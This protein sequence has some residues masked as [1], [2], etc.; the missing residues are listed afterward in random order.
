MRHLAAILVA[1]VVGFSSLMAKDEAS[2]IARLH[3]L[4]DDLINPKIA[5]YNGRLVKEMGDGMLLEFRSVVEAVRFAI[6]VQATIVSRISDAPIDDQIV[7]RMGVNLGDVVVNDEDILG[8]G[9][10]LAAR[11]ESHAEPG[12]ICISASAYDQ[13]AGKIDAT[14]EPLGPVE[15]KNIAN[16]VEVFSVKIDEK[17]HSLVTPVVAAID[18]ATAY[19]S[20]SGL[21]VTAAVALALVVGGLFWWQPWI[22]KVEPA[23]LTAMT[24]DLPDKPSIV[25]LPFENFSG[26]SEQDYFAN[27]MTDDL[28]TGLSHLPELFVISRNT[29]FTYKDQPVTIRDVAEE[30]GVQYVMEGSV[31]RVGN[32]VRINVQLIDALSGYHVWAEK[33]D[34]QM[35]DVFAIQDEVVG[36]IVGAMATNIL[37]DHA[38]M[39]QTESTLAYDLLLQGRE[40][41]HAN[42][43]EDYLVA[44]DLFNQALD[45]DKDFN[46]AHAALAASYWEI[47]DNSWADRAGLTT[48]QAADRAREHLALAHREP[49]S[50]ARRVSARIALWSGNHDEALS[51]IARAIEIDP[52]DADSFNV[53][54]YIQVRAGLPEEAEQSARTAMRLN[55]HYTDFYLR[56]LSRALFHQG[57]YEEA[58]QVIERAIKT[59]PEYEYNYP[60]LASIYGQLGEEEK[61]AQAV[62]KYHELRGNSEGGNLTLQSMNDWTPF[63]NKEDLKRLQDGLR[64]AGVPDG[65]AAVD[66]DF[67][68]LVTK[69]SG[70]FSIEG[71]RTIELEEAKLLH[72]EGAL[73]V[74][75]RSA[76]TGY[77]KAH[78]P[79]AI[80]LDYKTKL[81]KKNLA[82]VA[83]NDTQIVFYCDGVYCYKSA[84][85][86]AKAK[87]WGYTNVL[88]FAEGMPGWKQAGYPTEP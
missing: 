47:F 61:A 51:E 42:T 52:N 46:R 66:V 56:N 3:A 16:P 18:V 50:E 14:I 25:V 15:F 35:E 40:H 5:Q 32:T 86:C 11:L 67:E 79:G 21:L 22:T 73:F 29:S 9:V 69:A 65:A 30:L 41:F 64:V 72:Q 43:P 60:L 4:R 34:R 76:S 44:I 45:E 26:D 13:L 38:I 57:G 24:L 63:R 7:Y 28:L 88:Y 31:R 70:G 33:Y 54:S 19:H 39:G 55:P 6:E 53:R 81:T 49:N 17:A 71:V 37:T 80:W 77:P 58:L 27:G 83:D 74:D 2:T 62:K 87:T 75:T 78:I 20:R 1:D 23:R 10:N 8:D 59:S 36:N 85:A 84:Y 68:T 12:G 82:A 48:T